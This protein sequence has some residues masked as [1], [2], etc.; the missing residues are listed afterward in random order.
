MILPM[1]LE[2]AH[3]FTAQVRK[4]IPIDMFEKDYWQKVMHEGLIPPCTDYNTLNRYKMYCTFVIN[5][6]GRYS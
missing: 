5:T 6:G 3:Q 1:T 4:V 2:E